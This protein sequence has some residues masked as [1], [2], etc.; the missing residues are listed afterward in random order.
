MTAILSTFSPLQRITHPCRPSETVLPGE[1]GWL[2]S[3][4]LLPFCVPELLSS[5]WIAPLQEAEVPLKR[6]G[7][8]EKNNPTTTTRSKDSKL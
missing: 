8:Q 6:K 2:Q 7:N 3:K 1:L 4:G 5:P